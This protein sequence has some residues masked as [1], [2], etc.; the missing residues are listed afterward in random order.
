MHAVYGSEDG[1]EKAAVEAVN[2]GVDLIL[3]SYD[4]D[5]YY[6]AMRALLKAEEQGKLDGEMLE[7]SGKRLEKKVS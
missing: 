7:K 1:L 3:I 4:K 6:K 5:L 2:A